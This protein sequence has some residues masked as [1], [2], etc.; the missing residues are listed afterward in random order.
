MKNTTMLAALGGLCV[1]GCAHEPA[2]TQ[3]LAGAMAAVR[4]AEEAG[5][6]HVPDAELQLKLAQEEIKQAD[7]LMAR[8]ENQ[9]ARDKIL[10]ARNDAELALSLTHEQEA[11]TRLNQYAQPNSGGEQGEIR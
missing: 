10:R 5:A 2:P 1:W 4:A 7:R 3:Q 8:D 9:K 11:A 6:A